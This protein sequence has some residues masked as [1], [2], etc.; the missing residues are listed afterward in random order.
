MLTSSLSCETWKLLF[1]SSTAGVC[2]SLSRQCTHGGILFALSENSGSWTCHMVCPV[3]SNIL[4]FQHSGASGASQMGV[5]QPPQHP[6][7]FPVSI[8]NVSLTPRSNQ[9]MNPA[10][11]VRSSQQ[12]GPRP[13][14]AFSSVCPYWCHFL[15]ANAIV[16]H[17]H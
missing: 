2:D 11:T 14:A 6:P 10:H 17:N 8:H 3:K 1:Y 9:E 12:Q 7:P 15:V 5:L 13:H 4:C 16:T